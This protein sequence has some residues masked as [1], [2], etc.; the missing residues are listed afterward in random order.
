MITVT[1]TAATQIR[2]AARQ[3]HSEGLAL[4]IAAKRLPDGRI[5]Y[6]MGFDDTGRDDDLQFSSEGVHLVVAPMSLELLSGTVIDYVELN[7]GEFQF[8]FMNPNDPDFVPP[9]ES[10]VP[11]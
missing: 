6:G 5:Q 2:T 9:D 3:G 8:V 11:E 7:P 4:R 10:A 1:A